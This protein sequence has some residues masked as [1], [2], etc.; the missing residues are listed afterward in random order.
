MLFRFKLK[1]TLFRCNDSRIRILPP[2]DIRLYEVLLSLAVAVFD[3]FPVGM[4]LPLIDAL[5]L[6]IPIVTAPSLQE[7]TSQHGVG[8]LNSYAI[9]HLDAFNYPLTIEDYA[10]YALSLQQDA[11]KRLLYRRVEPKISSNAANKMFKSHG[12]QLLDFFNQVINM[13]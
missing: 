11:Q 12:D 7:C 9:G 8:L 13:S 1:F 10:V 2:L 6:N 3:P 5:E 4:H